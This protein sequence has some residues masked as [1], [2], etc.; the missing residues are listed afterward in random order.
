MEFEILGRKCLDEIDGKYI[1]EKYKIKEGL[2][3]GR[4]LH[5]ERVIWMKKKFR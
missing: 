4:R 3:F 2:E 5:E 1:K